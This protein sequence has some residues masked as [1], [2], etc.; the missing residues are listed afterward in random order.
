MPVQTNLLL[1]LFL[2]DP[3]HQMN[4]VFKYNISSQNIYERALQKKKEI[5]CEIDKKINA[6]QNCGKYFFILQ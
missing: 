5:V 1:T 3:V 6:N 2:D 4:L